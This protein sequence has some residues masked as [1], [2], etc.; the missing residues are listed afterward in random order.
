[1]GRLLFLSVLA[2]TSVMV[3]SRSDYQSVQRK[4]QQIEK[5]QTRPGSRIPITAREL[6]AYVQTE[7]PKVAPPGVRKPSVE[8]LGDNRA[9]GRALVD[10]V[11][12]RSAQG[13]PPNWLVRKLLEGEHDVRVTTRVRSGGGKAVVD[14]EQVEV[15]G[16]PI[17]GGALDFLIQNYLVPNYP[18]A[19]IGRPFDLKYGMDRIEVTP[20]T[21][22]VV[23]Q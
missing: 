20:G 21:A 16:L 10:F 4:F 14:I 17:S 23:M 19:K 2:A 13:K 8:L 9:S 6:N 3:G 18:D 1:M 11:R 12:L 22:Y 5:Q 15:A 7:L